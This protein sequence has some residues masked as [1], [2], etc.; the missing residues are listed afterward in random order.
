MLLTAD[1]KKIIL[2]DIPMIDVRAPV[3]FNKGAFPN[4]VNLPILS[5]EERH[6]IGIKYKEDGNEAAKALGYEMVSG[7]I[8]ESRVNGWINF[9]KSNPQTCLYCF[10]GGSR[11]TISQEWIHEAGVDIKKLEGGYKAYRSYL[12]EV[13]SGTWMKA[14]PVTLGGHTGSGKTKVIYNV[15]KA[16]DLEG[17]AHHRGSAF[18]RYIDSQPRQIDF[19]NHL[20]YN[21]VKHD[22]KGYKHLII[23]D[24]SFNVGKC[25]INR[26]LFKWFR[27]NTMVILDVSFKERIQN[28]LEEYVI[29]SQKNH[30]ERYGE[31]KGLAL[32]F[33]YIESSMKKVKKRLGGDR[34]KNIFGTFKNNYEAQLATNNYTP[35]EEWITVFL[36]DYYDPRYEYQMV[37]SIRPIEF[38]GNAKE[39][40]D[41]LNALD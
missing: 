7:D 15:D 23:E 39:V 16:I 6:I 9:I 20:A 34:F 12:L 29:E 27:S 26:N 25:F 37:K 18:G 21:L 14:K 10:R 5:D 19:E 2:E 32:W 11:S 22:A 4:T 24:E 1:Y 35:H 17:I 38:K 33:D 28:T 3:E 13:L 30:M 41:Y 31:Q 8:K 40:T 36:R